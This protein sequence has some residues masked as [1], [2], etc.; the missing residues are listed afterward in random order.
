MSAQ[1]EQLDVEP[2]RIDV[3]DAVLDD[4]RDRLAR[5][6]WADQI[7]GSG[8]DYGTD[9][10]Y[11]QELC[12]YWR[13]SFDWRTVEQTLNQWPQWTTTVLGQRLHYIPAN[14]AVADA[15]PLVTSRASLGPTQE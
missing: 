10:Q 12:E 3:P 8:W 7:P 6:R 13:T 9:E 5:T 14:P 15:L 2:F 1:L 11:L 4:L